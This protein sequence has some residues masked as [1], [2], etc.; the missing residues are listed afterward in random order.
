MTTCKTCDGMGQHQIENFVFPY[1]PKT[2]TCENCGGDGFEPEPE[3][4][5][6]EVSDWASGLSVAELSESLLKHESDELRH[7]ASRRLVA[8]HL[9]EQAMSEQLLELEEKVKTATSEKDALKQAAKE[10]FQT[11]GAALKTGK[12][13]MGGNHDM[14]HF[15]RQAMQKLDVLVFDRGEKN[16]HM[17]KLHEPSP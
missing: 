14:C 13:H 9:A 2:V 10:Y 3:P 16:T 7:E 4:E 1:R 15:V 5:E 8:Y 6:D 11:V 12:F 17:P